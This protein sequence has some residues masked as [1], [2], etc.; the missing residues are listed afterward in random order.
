MAVKMFDFAAAA[1]RPL[2]AARAQHLRNA[3]RA[4]ELDD[5]GCFDQEASTQ[6]VSKILIL[7]W[8]RQGSN[9]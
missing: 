1:A 9:L 4:L 7:W 2:A 5:L 6:N 8:V 3:A